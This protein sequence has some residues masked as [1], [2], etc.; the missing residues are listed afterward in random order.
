MLMDFFQKI[1]L[2]FQNNTTVPLE[3]QHRFLKRLYQ[4]L[5]NGYSLLNSLNLMKLEKDLKE[6]SI[7]VKFELSKGV[8]LSKVLKKEIG[9]ASCRERVKK[10]AEAGTCIVKKRKTK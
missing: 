5:N 9:R 8:Q 4:L 10:R 6:I 1:K 3:K 2:H 7:Q